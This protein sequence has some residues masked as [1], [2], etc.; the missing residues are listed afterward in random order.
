MCGYANATSLV[1]AVVNQK[2][3]LSFFVTDQNAIVTLQTDNGK[4]AII[5][6]IRTATELNDS[7]EFATGATSSHTDGVLFTY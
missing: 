5:Q 6:T 4:H 3:G 2:D 1:N 7:W